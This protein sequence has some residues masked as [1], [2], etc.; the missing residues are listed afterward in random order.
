MAD[1]KELIE[2]YK[3]KK[4]DIKRRLR[5]FEEVGKGSAKDIFTELC[6]CI[7][8][9]QSN[10]RQCDKAIEELKS[11]RLLFKA[12]AG[13]I[14]PILKGRARFH[15]KKAD[16]LVNARR[17]FDKSILSR[18]NILDVRKKIVENIKGIGYKEASHFLRNIGLGRDIAILDRHILKNLKR[19]GVIGAV[20]LS[21]SV[22]SYLN[23]EKSAR[24]F[25]E[26]IGLG[27]G[28]LDL[29]FWSRETGEIFK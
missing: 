5:E 24:S 10:A 16:Y 11:K 4:D 7:L 14:R 23:I 18:G 2:E 20:P 28:E 1:H 29:L 6:F 25:A 19:Y 9:P 21:I 12:P 26:K 3:Q 15:N 27:L 13:M 8:T 17:S 22:R